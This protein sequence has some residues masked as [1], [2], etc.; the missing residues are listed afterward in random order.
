MESG[1][2]DVVS[3][4]RDSPNNTCERTKLNK[5]KAKAAWIIKSDISDALFLQVENDNNPE[6]CWN[7]LQETS[8]QIGQDIVYALLSEV[9]QYLATRKL[10][11]LTGKPIINHRLAEI[12]SIIDR[13]LAGT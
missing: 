4:D 6:T 7:T 2:W 9:V 10:E 12:T 5:D 8:S 3:R 11:R 1:I 13:L